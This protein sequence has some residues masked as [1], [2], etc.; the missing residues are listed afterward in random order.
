MNFITNSFCSLGI[1]VHLQQHTGTGEQLSQQ[2]AW[3]E[4]PNFPTS[5]SSLVNGLL[6]MKDKG[7]L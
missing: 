7:N 3:L 2:L 4:I 1:W 5:P 6:K